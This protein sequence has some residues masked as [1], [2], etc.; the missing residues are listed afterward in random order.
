MK[1]AFAFLLVG[2]LLAW[3]AIQNLWLGLL[4]W[5][6]ISFLV[7]SLA[8]FRQDVR[9]FGKRTD[10]S[11][12]LFATAVLL[13]YLLFARGVWELQILFEKRPAWHQVTERVIIGR[14]LKENELPA[15]VVGL[16]DLTSELHDLP[17]IKNRAGYACE[18]VLDAGT[19]AVTTALKWADH[20]RQLPDG[21]FVVHC[22]NGS[23]RSGHV[24]AIW[25]LA[26]ELADSPE[27]AIAQVQAARPLVRLNRLQTT[28]VYLAHQ[29]VF[30]NRKPAT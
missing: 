16:L 11:R 23:G 10:G 8:Y 26:W 12:N 27:E 15:N 19:L 7:V 9:Y 17:A 5:P 30:S 29:F 28:Q 13:P 21:V 25:L 24:V 1:Y 20:V 6:A 18:P 14:R 4:F 22:A 3:L 2:L